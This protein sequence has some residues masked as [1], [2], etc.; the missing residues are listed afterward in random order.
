MKLSRTQEMFSRNLAQE[1]VFFW[2]NPLKK[3][4]TIK[5][6]FQYSLFYQKDIQSNLFKKTSADIKRPRA[7]FLSVGHRVPSRSKHSQLVST[8]SF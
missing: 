4:K 2:E 7:F 1:A 6:G 8:I 3:L 5:L